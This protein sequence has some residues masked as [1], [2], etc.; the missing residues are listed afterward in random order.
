MFEE[1][2]R[3]KNYII[4]IT[5]FILSLIIGIFIFF[6]C[7]KSSVEINSKETLTT[8]VKRQS[9]HLNTILNI[10]YSYLHEIA[11]DMSKSDDLFSQDN[12]T[13]LQVLMNKT[14]LNRTAVI[15]PNGDALY[16]NE[17]IKNVSEISYSN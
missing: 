9:E 5:L 7:V 1:R 16:D 3:F 2:F 6:N 15:N 17:I 4:S 10:N 8:N 13:R 12:L 11:Q 14:N